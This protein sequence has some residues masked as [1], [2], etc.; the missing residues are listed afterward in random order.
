MIFVAASVYPIPCVQAWLETRLASDQAVQRVQDLFVSTGA[1]L[2]GATAIVTSLVLFAMQVNVERMPHRLFRRFSEDRNLLLAFA[3]AFVLAVSVASLS[4]VVELDNLAVVLVASVW[5]ILLILTLFLYAY[6]RALRLINPLDQLQML[7]DDARIELR[8]WAHQIE[9]V[10]PLLVDEDQAEIDPSEK[11][12]MPDAARA[13]F[14]RLRPH[15]TAE[16]SRS[17]QYAM[18]FARRYAEQ[19]DY[20]VASGGL[21]AVIGINAAYVE[22]KGKTFYSDNLLI[23][24]PLASDTFIT[25]SLEHLRQNVDGAIR[26][27]DERQIEQSLQA[28]GALVPVYL[29]INYANAHAEKYHA[30]LASGYLANAIQAVVPHNLTDVLMEGQRL[31]GRAA[32]QFLAAGQAN[33]PA[34]LSEKVATLAGAT[35]VSESHRPV[36]LEGVQQ[37]AH[38]TF[39]LLRSSS[40][41]AA[42]ALRK[43]HENVVFVAKL[44]LKVPSVP[45]GNIHASTLAPYYSSSDMQSLRVHLTELVN[46]AGAA[47]ADDE[48]AR[49]VIRNL[50]GWSDGLY[51]TT[52]EL[53]LESIAVRSHFTIHMFQWIQGFTEILL[54]ASNAPACD[55]HT[56]LDLRKNAGWLIATL[57]WIPKD[58][59]T[60][61]FVETFGLTEILFEAAMNARERD[62]DDIAVDVDRMLVSWAFKGGRYITGWGVLER[63]LSGCAA[64]AL[65]AGSGTVEALK[66]A[67]RDHLQRDGAP[68]PEVRAHGAHGLRRQAQDLAERSAEPSYTLSI[69]D[70]VMQDL[71]YR[72][73]VTLLE[74]IAEVLDVT[75]Q[76]TASG[77]QG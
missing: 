31:L 30:Q 58:E 68:E 59:E 8:R 71:D 23:Q 36:S 44:L 14:F 48:N 64:L 66:S 33:Y 2:I 11:E 20:E 45:I 17:V 63:G 62:C 6:R 10:R 77:T 12:L 18:A 56:R 39:V 42:Y 15:W 32:Q 47:E 41:N 51:R 4:T 53:L 55:P 22:A 3:S 21:T 5:A 73:L 25:E 76:P 28:I 40:H 52:K 7:L 38:L 37:L 72:L 75:P 69:M 13:M 35:C 74:E 60:V 29:G 26:R 70:R 50:E 67:I 34:V 16:A 1:A 49:T 61:T 9:R 27:R 19:G 24:N 54:A 65:I 43:V 46:A 57:D